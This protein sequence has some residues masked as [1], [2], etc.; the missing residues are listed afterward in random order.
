M[1]VKLSGNQF[2]SPRDQPIL[3]NNMVFIRSVQP[4]S[5]AEVAGLEPDD[6]LMLIN[7]KV[8]DS[9]DASNAHTDSAVVTCMVRRGAHEI[10][11]RFSKSSANATLGCSLKYG[12]HINA[13][14][15]ALSATTS[16]NGCDVRDTGLD[17]R[18][19]KVLAKVATAQR[20]M[21]F[22]ITH[23]QRQASFADATLQ[24]VDAILV[25]NDLSI[26]R[27][28]TQVRHICRQQP[29]A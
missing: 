2:A 20:V 14:A 4:D 28:L 10:E 12:Q 9:F 19:A 29:N 7:G 25:A 17:V 1:Q 16:L 27:S 5:P 13:M 23:D 6:Q 15:R 18:W 26:S 3:L 21:L 11:I 8:V 24:P 22:G